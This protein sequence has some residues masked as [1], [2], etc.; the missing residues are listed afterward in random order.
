M[1]NFFDT[2]PASHKR[3]DL[4]PFLAQRLNFTTPLLNRFVR[5][6]SREVGLKAPRDLFIL[7]MVAHR[8]FTQAELIKILDFNAPTLSK[9]VDALV[10]G[11]Y[12]TREQSA[13]DRR[14]TILS[15][16]PKGRD[17]LAQTRVVNE[18]LLGE[19]LAEATDEELVGL[20]DATNT[21]TRLITLRMA[22][23]PHPHGPHAHAH[24]AH[25]HHKHSVPK[26]DI[27]E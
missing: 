4:L 24:M 21:L 20:L 19:M 26:E 3:E 7:T 13:D 5:M 6:S 11:G 15:I 14:A 12:I 23:H 22:T 25:P 2:Q 16:T 1:H 8:P 9:Q 18:R 27:H 17:V 10:Q